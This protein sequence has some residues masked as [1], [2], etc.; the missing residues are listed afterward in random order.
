M[1]LSKQFW[2]TTAVVWDVGKN[3]NLTIKDFLVNYPALGPI[4]FKARQKCFNNN[5][6]YKQHDNIVLRKYN[7]AS[8]DKIDVRM[9]FGATD[10]KRMQSLT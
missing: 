8:C 4:S 6:V 3:L 2:Q 10:D 5:L 1:R 7:E 9:D